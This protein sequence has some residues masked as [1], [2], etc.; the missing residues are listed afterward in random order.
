[1][2]GCWG[3]G[4]IDELA[5][6]FPQFRFFSEA[7]LK[8]TSES[9]KLAGL[10][11]KPGGYL[12]FSLS[13]SLAVFILSLL[14]L[15]L[16]FELLLAIAF[17]LIVFALAYLFLLGLPSI[18]A[19]RRAQGIESDLPIALRSIAT[20]LAVGVS[21]EKCLAHAAQSGYSIAPEMGEA[22]A[23][24]EHGGSNV[25]DALRG[26]ASRVDSLVVKRAVQQ[27]IEAYGHGSKGEGLRH[28]A[29]ELIEAQ[30]AGTR[31][32]SARIAFL[33]LLFV[34]VSCIVPALF[35]AYAVVGSAFLS[36]AFSASDIWFAYAIG[37]PLAGSA[38]LLAIYEK[39][40]KNLGR[41]KGGILSK[42]QV[43]L[44]DKTLGRMGIGAGFGKALVF[45]IGAAVPIALIL[46]FGSF[47]L[48]YEPWIA[49]L[50]FA[51]PVLVYFLM[52]RK[53]EARTAEIEA[54]LPDALL[55]ASSFSKGTPLDKIIKSIAD[56][57]YGPLSIEFA[58]AHSQIKSGA[59]VPSALSSISEEND[60]V[61]LSRATE[62]LSQAY[63]AGG[64][65]SMALKET[66]AD[67]F[68]IFSIVRE[69]E[70]TL[71][72]QKYTL[73][74]GGA[75]LVPLVLGAITNVIS[76]LGGQGME[77]ISSMSSLERASLISA[78]IGAAQIYLVIYSLLASL[79]I[80]Q[81]GGSWRNFI[82]Y[83]VMMAPVSLF[84]YNLAM[85]VHVLG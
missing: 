65:M 50:P 56:S 13:L 66:A 69:R 81:L 31:E 16:S 43:V 58:A 2:T 8:K 57:G 25:P 77:L 32:H 24:I 22:M 52:V 73:L 11:A 53:I 26:I 35:Q 47:A 39:T 14:F 85:S 30:K 27:M 29:D 40:P 18:L 83:F 3:D 71:A 70:S 74:F 76:K 38:V 37:F 20:E 78:S 6:S 51:I 28:L 17:S 45:L 7:G 61:L 55:H 4:L 62:L 63:S 19:K 64:E 54:R 46:L 15:L 41:R 67:M 23:E 33:G 10:R 5:D 1:M 68:S 60:S 9:L 49:L 79:F 84:A 48:R 59:D 36:S 75:L 82:V 34:A 44:A 42:K 72:L 80:A 12:S 21:F